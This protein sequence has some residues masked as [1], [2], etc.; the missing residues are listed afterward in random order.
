MD[1]L[2]GRIAITT[3]SSFGQ[4]VAGDLASENRNVARGGLPSFTCGI[5]TNWSREA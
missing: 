3:G 5:E 1:Q 2:D 4:G